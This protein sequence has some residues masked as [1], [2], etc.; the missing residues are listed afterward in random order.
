MRGQ[1]LAIVKRVVFPPGFVSAATVDVHMLPALLPPGTG[2][3][4]ESRSQDSL[5]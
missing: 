3:L 5:S 1:V 4:H 2:F